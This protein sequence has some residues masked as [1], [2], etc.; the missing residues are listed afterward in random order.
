MQLLLTDQRLH[1]GLAL[2]LIAAL[3][4][5]CSCRSPACAAQGA[6]ASR[7]KAAAGTPAGHRPPCTDLQQMGMPAIRQH[8][9]VGA[10]EAQL[11]RRLQLTR[12]RRPMLGRMRRG[13]ASWMLHCGTWCAL[14]AGLFAGSL[15]DCLFAGR[16]QEQVQRKR[17]VCKAATHTP[18]SVHQPLE[19]R[20]SRSR[21]L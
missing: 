3:A 9:A 7:Q 17:T 10:L 4:A 20:D 21:H 6:S 16:L 12:M 8:P 5:A 15:K 19:W 2:P 1:C 14:C 18:V 13:I 11:R